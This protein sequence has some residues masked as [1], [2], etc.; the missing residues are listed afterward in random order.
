MEYGGRAEGPGQGGWSTKALEEAHAKSGLLSG[1]TG[2]KQMRVWS[3]KGNWD[4]ASI[5]GIPKSEPFVS[6][7]AR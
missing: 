7:D 3:G 6:T 5:L 1:G 4:M 2:W